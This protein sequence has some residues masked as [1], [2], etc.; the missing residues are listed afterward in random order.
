MA[1]G[2]DDFARRLRKGREGV[3]FER[4][5]RVLC[6]LLDEWCAYPGARTQT[7]PEPARDC[8]DSICFDKFAVLISRV[9]G[10]YFDESG[11][12]L[13]ANIDEVDEAQRRSVISFP[14]P[15]QLIP[16]KHGRGLAVVKDIE[17]P[18]YILEILYKLQQEGLLPYFTVDAHNRNP[19]H[20]DTTVKTGFEV[21]N[22]DSFL[23]DFTKLERDVLA[24]FAVALKHLSAPEI[25]ALGTHSNAR[26]TIDDI[27]REFR[28]LER[29]GLWDDLLTRLAAGHDFSLPAQELLGYAD[30]AHRKSAENRRAYET[31]RDTL[32]RE[33]RDEK[34]R[35]VIKGCHQEDGVIWNLP[36][37]KRLARQASLLLGSANYLVAV[38][39]FLQHPEQTSKRTP[40]THWR[41][42]D[43]GLVRL[44]GFDPAKGLPAEPSDAVES[45]PGRLRASVL[46]QLTDLLSNLR[47]EIN[48]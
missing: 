38:S 44:D 13:V 7:N 25:R 14:F 34:L 37:V 36:E 45:N 28:Y 12:K 4:A 42:W 24:D 2:D 32:I 15:L 35:Q 17:R 26:D 47:L 48:A 27:K 18:R 19:S 16:G 9:W 23:E 46:D 8:L 21:S 20:P 5:F 1:A 6:Y 40:S 30:E 11:R 39:H 3:Q 33:V 41:R 31:A 43:E 22:R 10:K 29:H